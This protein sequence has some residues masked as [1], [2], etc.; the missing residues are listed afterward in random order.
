MAETLDEL[1]QKATQQRRF[2]IHGLLRTVARR[3]MK[4]PEVYR[5]L[6]GKVAPRRLV[7]LLAKCGNSQTH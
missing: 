1:C 2:P 6:C 5:E 3:A 7:D 4:T